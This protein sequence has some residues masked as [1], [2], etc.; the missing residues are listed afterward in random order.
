M[1]V[2]SNVGTQL[3][4]SLKCSQSVAFKDSFHET[5]AF[6]SAVAIRWR[7]SSLT[8]DGVVEG[9]PLCLGEL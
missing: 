7:A 1:A 5:A 2:T 3:R 4:G 6:F 8:W 9:A